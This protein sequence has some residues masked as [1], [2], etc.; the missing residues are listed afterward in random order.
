MTI[1]AKKINF[2]ILFSDNSRRTSRNIYLLEPLLMIDSEAKFHQ[3]LLKVPMML[4]THYN[5]QYFFILLL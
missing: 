2:Q 1:I 3:T 4:V 5:S